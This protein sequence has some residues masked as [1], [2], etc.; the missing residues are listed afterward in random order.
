MEVIGCAAWGKAADGLAETGMKSY[1]LAKLVGSE[2]LG[3]TGDLERSAGKS[4]AKEKRVTLTSKSVVVL[5]EA[6]AVGTKELAK[7]VRAVEKTG[8]K[9]VMLGDAQQLQPLS[10]GAPFAAT[11][12]KLGAVKLT[13]IVRQLNLW[14]RRAVKLLAHGRSARALHEYARRGFVHVAKSKQHAMKELVQAYARS[15]LTHVKEKLILAGTNEEVAQLNKMV[16]T[17]RRHL[18]GSASIRV[19]T[20][21]IHENDQVL[22][23][24]NQQM[25]GRL[26][27]FRGREDVA[28]KNGSFGTVL[29]IDRLRMQ[30][31]V[32]LFNGKVV[33]VKLREYKSL[34]LGYAATVH[35]AQGSTVDAC[36]VLTG[37]HMTHRQSAYVEASRARSNT[38]FFLSE[39]DAGE[40]LSKLTKAMSEDRSKSLAVST[41][42]KLVEPTVSNGLELHL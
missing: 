34:E 39:E 11:C 41:E 38:H 26:R 12:R 21:V 14:Q 22:F 6:G 36:Y 29:K 27:P 16:Q 3:F 37:S 4:R 35:R 10:Y 7:L 31:H 1:T 19:G 2:E 18:L 28:V 24:K 20:S 33:H 42:R 40:K 15:G 9:L 8:A 5:D 17:A 13:T 25:T 23:R 30:I 32:R